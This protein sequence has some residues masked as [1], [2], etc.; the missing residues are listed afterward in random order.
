MYTQTIQLLALS[1]RVV[2]KKSTLNIRV[3]RAKIEKGNNDLLIRQII[4]GRSW[5]T[6]LN[7][8]T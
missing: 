1:H 2:L 3:R 8:M 4:K 7:K 5:W 6:T